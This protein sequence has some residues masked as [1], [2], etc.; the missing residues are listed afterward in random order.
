MLDYN[1][2]EIPYY[3][4]TPVMFTIIDHNFSNTTH[5]K[6]VYNHEILV[7]LLINYPYLP[8]YTTNLSL[9]IRKEVYLFHPRE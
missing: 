2:I 7:K 4:E 9:E 5:L 6:F 1:R 8:I 3:H